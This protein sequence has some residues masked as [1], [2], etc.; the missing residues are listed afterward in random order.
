M[1]S[2]EYFFL[3]I[4]FYLSVYAVCR[5]NAGLQRQIAEKLINISSILS[6][7]SL[8]WTFTNKSQ[9]LASAATQVLGGK[10]EKVLEQNDE[11]P[12][13]RR[14][15]LALSTRHVT[16]PILRLPTVSLPGRCRVTGLRGLTVRAG[17]QRYGWQLS[18][19]RWDSVALS[20]WSAGQISTIFHQ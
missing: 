3:F 6:S 10:I 1:F 16:C 2:T 13:K 15:Y 11:P 19:L 20:D 8:L 14:H 5:W 7:R 17:E 18:I 4:I 9:P 12:P